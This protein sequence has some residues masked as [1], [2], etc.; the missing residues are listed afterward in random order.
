MRDTSP[1]AAH[2]NVKVFLSH[3]GLLSLQETIFHATPVL[4]LP[5]FGD[6]PK[7]AALIQ[8]EGYGRRLE[9]E[10]LTVDLLVETLQ[11]II[12]NPRYLRVDYPFLFL[13]IFIDFHAR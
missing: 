10:E 7:V 3:G 5:I 12:S 11:E 9:W 1:P 8:N 2:P 13:N 6:Q 4:A